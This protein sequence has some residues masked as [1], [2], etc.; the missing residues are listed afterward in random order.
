MEE[1][2]E[3]T[4]VLLKPDAIDRGLIGEI[5]NRFEKVGLKIAGLKMVHPDEDLAKRHYTED[6]AE[7][8]GQHVRDMAVGMIMEAPIV[9]FVLEGIEA[10]E[11]VRKM[12]GTTEPK[13]AAPGTIRGDYSHVSFKHADAK[14]LPIYNLIHASGDK[15]DAEKEIPV[16]FTPEELYDHKPAYT[17]RTIAY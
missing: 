4:L 9:A 3:R 15:A 13:S 2:L 10:V 6:L 1:T 14:K 17:G 11:L 8:R 7:R 12:V 5:I 16:W